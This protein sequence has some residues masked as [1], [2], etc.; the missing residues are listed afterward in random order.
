MNYNSEVSRHLK[1]SGDSQHYECV[2]Y[3]H[4]RCDKNEPFYIGIGKTKK[5]AYSKKGRNNHW[6]NITS[7]S[8]YEV[9]IL[10]DGVSWDFAKEKEK[11][12]ILIYGRKDI[13]TGVLCNMTDGGDGTLGR[14]FDGSIYAGIP[15]S[16][17]TKMKI[18]KA[19]KGK[20][21]SKD[22]IEKIRESKVG[23]NNFFYGKNLSKEHREKIS[24]AKK[25]AK[26]SEES[27]EKMSLAKRKMVIDIETGIIYDSL[28][29]ACKDLNLNYSTQTVRIHRNN[30]KNKFKY[31]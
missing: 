4:I 21:L 19:H 7:K 10:F 8:D 2:V 3:R 24:K 28:M 13:G 31:I 5:R 26:M 27:K 22:H 12:F 20:K 1:D 15:R 6:K 25:G 23:K 9:D 18:S 14:V 30:N 17:D 16:E 11:E 29:S